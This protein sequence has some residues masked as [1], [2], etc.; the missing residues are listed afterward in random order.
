MNIVT[1]QIDN[2]HVT[3]VPAMPGMNTVD[4]RV[5]AHIN[6]STPDCFLSQGQATAVTTTGEIGWQPLALDPALGANWYSAQ[7]TILGLLRPGD[8]IWA[9]VDACE[10]CWS[11]ESGNSAPIAVP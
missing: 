7:F 10:E 11:C 2:L 8:V 1:I 4:F 3:P 9:K 6:L 5:K